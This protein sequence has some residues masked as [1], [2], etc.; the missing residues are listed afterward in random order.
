MYHEMNNLKEKYSAL[1][2]R[3]PICNYLRFSNKHERLMKRLTCAVLLA[4][5][6]TT[7]CNSDKL[8]NSGTIHPNNE[9]ADKFDSKPHDLSAKCGKNSFTRPTITRIF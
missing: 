7:A 4:T 1:I 3:P 5:L 2:L 9:Q 6:L 8:I